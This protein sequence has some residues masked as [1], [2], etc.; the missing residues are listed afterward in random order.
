M[1]YSGFKGLPRRTASDKVLRDKPFKFAKIAKFD[2]YLRGLALMVYKFFDEKPRG[3]STNLT[4]TSFG[5][6]NQ[7]LTDELY[8]SIIWKF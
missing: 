5:S 6:E 1:D 4:R 2:G 8:K 7:Q 3:I